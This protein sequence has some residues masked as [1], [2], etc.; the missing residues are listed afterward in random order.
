ELAIGQTE[1]RVR[2]G[3][4]AHVGDDPVFLSGGLNGPA[5][6]TIEGLGNR[7]EAPGIEGEHRSLGENHEVSTILRGARDVLPDEGEVRLDIRLGA[8]LDHGDTHATRVTRN[9][10]PRWRSWGLDLG[11]SAAAVDTPA[12]AIHRKRHSNRA[13]FRSAARGVFLNAPA[14]GDD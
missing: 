14:A 12:A 6:G 11:A 2:R 4:H 3:K 9:H 10:T 1:N 8:H 5:E 7:V 13:A